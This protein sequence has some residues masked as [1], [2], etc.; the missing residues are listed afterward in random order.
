M[1]AISYALLWVCVGF[2]ALMVIAASAE[3]KAVTV[4]GQVPLTGLPAGVIAPGFDYVEAPT[5]PPKSSMEL[6]GRDVLLL[7]LSPGCDRCK[8][9][10]TAVAPLFRPLE[11]VSIVAACEGDEKDRAEL[12]RA[13]GPSVKLVASDVD[14]LRTA[15]RAGGFPAAVFIDSSGTAQRSLYPRS[16]TELA[17]VYRTLGVVTQKSGQRVSVAV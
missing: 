6:R 2:L 9:I 3:L 15:Y 5:M 11:S 7:F 1:F 12:A 17:D 4:G 16:A 8:L 10:A 14:R 13:L